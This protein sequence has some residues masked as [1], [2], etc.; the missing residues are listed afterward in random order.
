MINFPLTVVDNFLENPDK[1]RNFALHQEFFKDDENRYPGM[2]TKAI[3]EIDPF[4]CNE[5]IKKVFSIY[6]NFN[7]EELAWNV[8]A[9]FQL[10]DSSY[11]EGWIHQDINKTTAIIYLSPN[12]DLKNGTSIYK[13][14]NNVLNANL[15]FFANKKLSFF[16]GDVSCEESKTDRDQNNAQFE[17]TI[18]VSNVYNRL[19]LFDANEYHSAQSFVNDSKEQR[20]TLIFFINSVSVPKTPIE[21]SKFYKI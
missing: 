3:S 18:N 4:F 21:R 20:L 19:L 17:E 16:K 5:L 1:V 2:R 6:F 13:T 7:N 9:R 10:I 8:D 14:K 12:S 15:D 11:G